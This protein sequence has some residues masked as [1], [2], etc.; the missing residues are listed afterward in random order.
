[1]KF[2]IDRSVLSDA[3]VNA[4]KA[5]AV[6]STIPALEG[7]LINLKDNVITITGYDLE[8]GIKCIVSPT[9]AI[10]DGEI[11]VNAK[12]FGEMIRKMPSG[13]VEISSEGDN[14]TIKS[15]SVVY[16]VVGVSGDNYPNIP[17]LKK[18]ITFYV[19]ESVMKSMIRQTIHAVAL[20]D[21]KPVHMGSKFHIE[22]NIL[23]VVSVDGVRMAKRV[24]PVEYNDID[25]VVP[26]K[27]LDEFMKMLSDE[28]NE[29]KISVCIDRNQIC[30]SKEDYII[31][32]RL[33]EGNFIDYDKIMNFEE[34]MTASVN[35]VDFS[36]SLDRTLLLNTDKYKCPVICVFENDELHIDIKTSVGKMSDVIPIKYSGEKLEIAFNAKYMID[37]LNN[38][39]CDEVR[40]DCTG[41]LFPRRI[42]PMNDDSFVGIVLPVRNK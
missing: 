17:E 32:S 24:E 15:G 8:L 11:V 25:F 35:A 10:E 12:I 1:M 33:L 39:E 16:N 4:S 26:K 18:D 2:S 3:L 37:A 21:I 22:N 28:P 5:S 42:R 6:R 7:V 36:T 34:K 20:T 13:E 14:V 9:E 27:T 38:S 19:D 29:K 40:I 41:A 30:F 31:I 23:S